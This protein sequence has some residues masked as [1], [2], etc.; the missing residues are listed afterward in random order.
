MFSENSAKLALFPGPCPA[1][2]CLQYG[3]LVSDKKLSSSML[4]VMKNWPHSQATPTFDLTASC[5]EKSIFPHSCEIK[6]GSGLGM[7]LMKSLAG[8]GG[9]GADMLN[10]KDGWT[11][12]INVG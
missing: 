5:G 9:G 4:Q 8:G 6:S 12:F 10:G 7:K 11:K 2:C 3:R 1:F